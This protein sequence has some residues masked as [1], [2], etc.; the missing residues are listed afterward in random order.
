MEFDE[1]KKE[2]RIKNNW[3]AHIANYFEHKKQKKLV[4]QSSIVNN[5]R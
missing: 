1:M 4:A 5:K 2:S 3:R